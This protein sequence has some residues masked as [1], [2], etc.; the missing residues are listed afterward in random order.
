MNDILSEMVNQLAPLVL[1]II[2]IVVLAVLSMILMKAKGIAEAQLN[3]DQRAL[4]GELA[5]VAVHMAEKEGADK[6]GADKAAMAQ[7]YVGEEL[8]KLGIDSINSADVAGTIIGAVQRA[9]KREIG[10]T[11]APE[12][13][14]SLMQNLMPKEP[15]PA[16]TQPTVPATP[17]D[18]VQAPA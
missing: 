8:A 12:D 17:A 6:A 3:A 14:A 2:G 5:A 11:V 1:Q 18:S 10:P 9:W 15:E 4:L 7:R 13:I 16:A